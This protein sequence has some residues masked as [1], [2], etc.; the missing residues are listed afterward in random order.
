MKRPRPSLVSVIVP[1]FDAIATIGHQ[2]DALAAHFADGASYPGWVEVSWSK[3]TG[4]GLEAII[5]ELK[6]LKLTIRNVPQESDAAGSA[7]F[8]TGEDAV[9]RILIGR[10]Y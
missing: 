6:A 2:L 8:F 7:C 9:E 3:P 5:E 1:T 10:A 4:V